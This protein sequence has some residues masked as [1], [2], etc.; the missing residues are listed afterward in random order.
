MPTYIKTCID[1]GKE[2]T[3][4]AHNAKRCKECIIIHDR[5]RKRKNYKR[6]KN[7]LKTCN[8]PKM[9]INDILRQLNRYNKRHKTCLTYGQFIQIKDRRVKNVKV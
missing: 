4:K 3:A 7:S 2:F 8:K 6:K 1:C 9:S 5:E